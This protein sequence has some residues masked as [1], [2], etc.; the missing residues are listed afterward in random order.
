MSDVPL[1]RCGQ[2]FGAP[3]GNTDNSRCYRFR[4]PVNLTLV[5]RPSGASRIFRIPD[6]T[7]VD[8]KVRILVDI[9]RP[10]N[11][12]R[13]RSLAAKGQSKIDTAEFDALKRNKLDA[14]VHDAVKAEWP[15]MRA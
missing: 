15:L 9:V 12:R 5:T 11:M 13:L 7:E 6:A 14:S 1:E 2:C 10:V 3:Y 8:I 4:P